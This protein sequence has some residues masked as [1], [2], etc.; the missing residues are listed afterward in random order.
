M[1]VYYSNNKNKG[2]EKVRH[3][4]KHTNLA[5]WNQ[6]N[7]QTPSRREIRLTV[8]QTSPLHLDDF[9]LMDDVLDQASGPL[10]LL[11][12]SKGGASISF[13]WAW[14]EFW[15]IIVYLQTAVCLSVSFRK[16]SSY[17]GSWGLLAAAT[18]SC[19][20]TTA[21]ISAS[22]LNSVPTTFHSSWWSADPAGLII[23]D[24]SE[25]WKTLS[26]NKRMGYISAHDDGCRGEKGWNVNYSG[27]ILAFLIKLFAPDKKQG[28]H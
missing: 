14:R 23:A 12:Y 13:G 24:D 7:H 4:F 18:D 17:R 2:S 22:Y 1:L 6:V 28:T 16:V 19:T 8:I 15:V 20:L 21:Q 25:F 27:T 11:N 9:F 3:K 26:T 5:T 10:M